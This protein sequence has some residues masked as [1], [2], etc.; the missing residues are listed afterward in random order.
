MS[1]V[2][3]TVLNMSL[4]A[5]YA[6]VMVMLVRFLLKRAPK[7]F[8]YALWLVVLLRLIIPVSFTSPVS[9]L[10][11][12]TNVIPQD[13]VVSSKPAIETGIEIIDRPVNQVIQTS[14]TPA[15]D[16]GT[17]QFESVKTVTPIGSVIEAA[18]VIWLLGIIM[19]VGYSFVSYFK[20]QQRLSLATLVSDNIY[21]S[22]RIR[23]PFV[24][25]FVKPRIYLPSGLADSE[26][27]HILRHEKYHI[28][29]RDYLIKPLALLTV[30]LHWFNPIIWSSYFLM[31]KDM[32]MSCDE[33]VIK[34]SGSSGA[35]VRTSYSSTLLKLAVKQ[36]G[37][38]S[39]LPFGESNV[40][41][42]IQ[43]ILNYKEPKF[44]FVI[45][46]IALII[47][48]ATGLLANPVK[49]LT[50]PLPA[51]VREFVYH[52][53]RSEHKYAH[54]NGYFYESPIIVEDGE[55]KLTIWAALTYPQKTELIYTV[56]GIKGRDYSINITEI[57]G[58]PVAEKYNLPHDSWGS[59]ANKGI[60]A[61]VSAHPLP[62]GKHELTVVMQSERL[63]QD[64]VVKVPVDADAMSHLY[65]T[66]TLYFEKT[67]EGIT[68]TAEKLIYSPFKVWVDLKVTYGP[69]TDVY[70]GGVLD[71]YYVAVDKG[72]ML[73]VQAAADN[74]VSGVRTYSMSFDRPRKGDGVKLVIPAI[75]VSYLAEDG[76]VI[77]EYETVGEFTTADIGK[78]KQLWDQEW[79]LNSWR[80][81]SPELEFVIEYSGDEFSF[82]WRIVGADGEILDAEFVN[83]TVGP[84]ASG[85]KGTYKYRLLTPAVGEPAKIV[86]MMEKF[87]E[88]KGPI[89][90]TLPL[91]D[92]GEE[93]LSSPRPYTNVKEALA[94]I[95]EQD[96]NDLIF[97]SVMFHYQNEDAFNA[98]QPTY[99]FVLYR[100]ELVDNQ[101][102]VVVYEVGE[103]IE[104]QYEDVSPSI[105]NP[106]PADLTNLKNTEESLI[107]KHQDR[108]HEVVG[109][110]REAGRDLAEEAFALGVTLQG[111]YSDEEWFLLNFDEKIIAAYNINTQELILAEGTNG[112]SWPPA[113]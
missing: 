40:K 10:P 21:E 22:D 53:S 83:T 34:E 27:S 91:P 55:V 1:S 82:V 86:A 88:V 49:K 18:A 26:I 45:V 50:T 38:F 111:Y 16:Q 97:V 90:I 56:E 108:T 52:G 76:S 69:G 5:S 77:Q 37:L 4:T 54:Q 42:R 100:N 13:I 72:S 8:S 81:E 93:P 36:K 24:L 61:T 29:R 103:T 60:Y 48:I 51:W 32:E 14:F 101:I 30:F 35:D 110:A 47:F 89:E 71:T 6:A 64:M 73:Q 104:K 106:T 3:I 113:S 96:K 102:P 107:K 39:P 66:K 63:T 23:T 2:F 7:V 25:G 74:L 58:K 9:L 94:A 15:A 87:H 17:E 11:G 78:T 85:Q 112:M 80:Y 12:E 31:V 98:R 109:A 95:K 84:G 67:I 62:T 20:L 65:Q 68:V 105:M 59:Y 44:W 33:K 99:L 75:V 70:L 41:A 46:T 79:T 28:K 43:N 19:L 92:L 57:D